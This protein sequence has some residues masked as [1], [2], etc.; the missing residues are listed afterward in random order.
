MDWQ[1]TGGDRPEVTPAIADAERIVGAWVVEMCDMPQVHPLLIELMNGYSE[2]LCRL[3]DEW[4][5][6]AQEAYRAT[7]GTYADHLHIL[8]THTDAHVE[9]D[10]L[11][12][13]SAG[14]NGYQTEPVEGGWCDQ[15]APG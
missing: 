5:E 3:E 14:A 6:E 11:V 7:F 1:F 10:G 8:D 13:V 4:L 12:I 2:N 15:S 9:I